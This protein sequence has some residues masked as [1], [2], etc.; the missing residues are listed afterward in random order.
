MISRTDLPV[1]FAVLM[2]R[3]RLLHEFSRTHESDVLICGGHV[4]SLTKGGKPMARLA[5]FSRNETRPP[6]H[7]LALMNPISDLWR[8][9][10]AGPAGEA[11]PLTQ[12]RLGLFPAKRACLLHGPSHP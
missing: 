3:A 9:R 8:A 7:E 10:S 4:P 11:K 5:L 6:V 12:K 1:L 2:K